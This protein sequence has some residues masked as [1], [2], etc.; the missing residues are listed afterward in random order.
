VLLFVRSPGYWA[1]NS[2]T[3][4]KGH[5]LRTTTI[6]L[7]C[8][9]VIGVPYGFWIV[10]N[11]TRK[12][13][14]PQLLSLATRLPPSPLRFEQVNGSARDIRPRITNVSIT[15]LNSDGRQDIL[16]C[17]A[18]RNTV[19]LQTLTENGEWQRRPL[20]PENTIGVPAHTSVT[21]IDLDGDADILVAVLRNVWPT[22]ARIGQV[23]LLENDGAENYVARVIAEDLRRVTDVQ[24]ADL[25][26]D[27]DLDLVV[28]EFGYL[29]GRVLWLENM[30]DGNFADHELQSLPGAIHVP[31]GDFDGDG[32]IDIAAV[33]SQN[34][35]EVWIFENTGGEKFHPVPRRVWSTTNYDLGLAGMVACDLDQDGD[36]DFLLSAG[37]NMELTY[38]CPQPNHGC[39]WL[40]NLG[41]LEFES[42]IIG[43]LAGT[44]AAD[45][46]DLDGDGD[47][48]IVLASM[49]NEWKENGATSLAWLENDGTQ[50]FTPWQLATKPTRLCTVS[51]GDLNGDGRPDIVTGSLQI[52]PPY[53]AEPSGVTVWL[54][55][56][57][58]TP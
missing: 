39:L 50:A 29:H 16:I 27:G 28:A 54:N 51:C 10:D 44:Y 45:A 32:D 6:V 7:L 24:S 33:I 18:V 2:R 49:F 56:I 12:N 55:S 47:L 19:W 42:H 31:V 14:P 48:D 26:S 22:D 53:E 4:L 41:D 8:A 43:T 17:D 40:E 3:A 13:R 38:P 57:E 11:A 34:D 9:A 5:F 46:A 20:V 30:G 21:D 58:A 37:D 35:E 36:T 1:V 15:D 23:V 52:Y 25:D